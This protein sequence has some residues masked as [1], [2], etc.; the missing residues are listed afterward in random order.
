MALPW[1]VEGRPRPQYAQYNGWQQADAIRARTAAL[2]QQNAPARPLPQTQNRSGGQ[3]LYGSD[4]GLQGVQQAPRNVQTWWDNLSE[5]RAEN[6]AEDQK[7]L[8]GKGEPDYSEV[9]KFSWPWEEENEGKSMKVWWDEN[10]TE[11]SQAIRGAEQ[12]VKFTE[13][14]VQQERDTKKR[15]EESKPAQ[16]QA[17]ADYYN[18]Q[19]SRTQADAERSQ[20]EKLSREET[21]SALT[22]DQWNAMSPVQQA[23]VQWNADLKAAVERDLELGLGGGHSAT[24]DELSNYQAGLDEMFGEE[25]R[26]VGVRGLNYAPETLALLQS[27]GMEGQLQGLSM[28]DFLL[29][30][31]A[32][33]DEEVQNLGQEGTRTQ[34]VQLANSLAKGQ[35]EYQQ[36]LLAKGEQMIAGLTSSANAETVESLGGTPRGV[37]PKNMEFADEGEEKLI[38]TY[39]WGL[40]NPEWDAEQTLSDIQA[41]LGVQGLEPEKQREV[42]NK[43]LAHSSNAAITGVWF[44]TAEEEY[45]VSA[46]SLR[47]PTDIAVLLGAVPFGEA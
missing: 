22:M 3:S 19:A 12:A 4:S 33:S 21:Y 37:I 42:Y 47:A 45:G 36:Q 44:P 28:D 31:A 43:M 41:D 38:T 6:R 26:S 16:R 34:R 39:L 13:T 30:D 8:Q 17:I 40:A 32:L 7:I 15:S 10:V 20:R 35:Q 5:T 27:R 18:A 24:S 2:R 29:M 1:Y 14:E 46:D 9:P 23:A 11:R 25:S